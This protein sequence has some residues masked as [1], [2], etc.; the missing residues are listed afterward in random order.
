VKVGLKAEKWVAKWDG[1]MVD[2]MV[3][4]KVVD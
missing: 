2:M 3:E 4:I 1:K